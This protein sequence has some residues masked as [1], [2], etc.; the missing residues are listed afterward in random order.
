MNDK[1]PARDIRPGDVAEGHRIAAVR[2]D[3]EQV[4]LTDENGKDRRYWS[5]QQI[6]GKKATARR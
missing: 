3:G 6:R 2:T 5:W 4:I 1:L